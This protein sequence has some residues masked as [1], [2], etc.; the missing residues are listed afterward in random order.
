M[1]LVAMAG[2]LTLDGWLQ[3]VWKL[4]YRRG[5]CRIP[6]GDRIEICRRVV[7]NRQ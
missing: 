6:R 3:L 4:K 2:L 5:L 1:D 7:V